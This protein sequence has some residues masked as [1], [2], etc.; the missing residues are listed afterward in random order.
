MRQQRRPRAIY[1]AYS[2]RPEMLLAVGFVAGLVQERRRSG[3]PKARN[4]LSS[5]ATSSGKIA[6][7]GS[8]GFLPSLI[9]GSATRPT[10]TGHK[11]PQKVMCCRRVALPQYDGKV[12]ERQV[13]S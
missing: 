8:A 11:G 12:N 1:A 10:P 4:V 5:L 7:Y 13:R 2:N 6:P 3:S 9:E